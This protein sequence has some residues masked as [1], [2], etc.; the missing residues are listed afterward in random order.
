M[1]CLETEILIGSP[2]DLRPAN[3]SVLFSR[4]TMPPGSAKWVS[5]V[6]R[7]CR[8]GG[9]VPISQRVADSFNA[10]NAAEHARGIEEIQSRPYVY[11]TRGYGSPTAGPAR[12]SWRPVRAKSRMGGS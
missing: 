2:F 4:E 1:R 10:W 6:G 12:R 5:A 3:T 11:G 9:S 7:I 8:C